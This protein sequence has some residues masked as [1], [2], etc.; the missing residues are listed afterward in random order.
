[1][2]PKKRLGNKNK[3][4]ALSPKIVGLPREQFGTRLCQ[5]I[6][7][8]KCQKT[9]YVSVRIANTKEG[10]CRNCA[11]KLLATYEHGRHIE[12]KKVSRTC[13]KC[14]QAFLV[15]EDIADKKSSLL[16]LD[17]LRGFEVWRGKAS[18]SN[19]A[20]KKSRPVLTK[21]GSNTTFRKNVNDTI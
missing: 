15:S 19:N 20:V 1:M 4:K 3:V 5:R 12:T 6:T 2:D 11:E 17:C 9:D 7:C 16:C 10:F 14:Q 13:Q 21:L 18:L 8:A